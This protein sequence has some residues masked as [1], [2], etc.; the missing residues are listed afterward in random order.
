MNKFDLLQKLVIAS[1]ITPFTLFL[2][3]YSAEASHLT[4]RYR[5]VVTDGE[6]AAINAVVGGLTD[7]DLLITNR[8]KKSNTVA[9]PNLRFE[10]PGIGGGNAAIVPIV[11]APDPRR[12]QGNMNFS[13]VLPPAIGGVP[14]NPV[15]AGEE[16]EITIGPLRSNFG[17]SAF[18]FTAGAGG[19]TRIRA[20]RGRVLSSTKHNPVVPAGSFLFPIL[21]ENSGDVPLVYSNFRIFS[22][23]DL[24]QTTKEETL[25][26]ITNFLDPSNDLFDSNGMLLIDPPGT[27]I[28][29]NTLL[30]EVPEYNS[31]TETLTLNGFTSLELPPFLLQD[32]ADTGI[33][34]TFARITFEDP[35]FG[36]VISDLAVGHQVSQ[37]QIVSEPS[38]IFSIFAVSTIGLV[39]TLKG[40]IKVISH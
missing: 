33:V 11:T 22:D 7:V 16:Y 9:L 15:L 29:L 4:L 20:G 8:A 27:E 2:G 26:A 40:K 10:S 17:N 13:Y 25:E 19:A 6:A 14:I 3:N 18:F 12:V 31:V 35:E 23:V 1:V 21:L 38:S 24:G 28:D 39:L 34:M 5:A 30:A 32:D 37:I 36:T